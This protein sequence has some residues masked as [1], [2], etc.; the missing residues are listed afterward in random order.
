MKP[1]AILN[2]VAIL[3]ALG[4]TAFADVTIS[5]DTMLTGDADYSGQTVTVTANATLDLAGHKLTAASISGDGAI[6]SGSAYTP[7]DMVTT[8]ASNAGRI[9]TG[10]KPKSTDRIETKFELGDAAKIKWIFG[11]Y[12]SNKRMDCYTGSGNLTFQLGSITTN[13]A[14]SVG[15]TYEVVLDGKNSKA[16]VVTGNTTTELEIDETTY[17]PSSNIFLFGPSDSTDGRNVS[18]CTMYYFR[19]Y[20]EGGNLKL[21]LIPMKRIADDAVGFYDTE[22]GTFLTLSS[23]ELTGADELTSVTTASDNTGYI[24][25]G[26]VPSCTDRVETK[27]NFAEYPSSSDGYFWLFSART[28]STAADLFE[29]YLS[30]NKHLYI[31]RCA[32][33]GHVGVVP[34]GTDLEIV[35][36]AGA[37]SFSINGEA[38]TPS[39]GFNNSD[40]T[41]TKCFRLFA[42]HPSGG[43]PCK[44]VT[45]YYFRVFDS[46]GALKMN[47]VPVKRTSDNAV[48]FCDRVRGGFYK[49]NTGTLSG[50][51][52]A[53]Q[54]P[55]ALTASGGTCTYTASNGKT[56]TYGD[57][58]NLFNNNFTYSTSDNTK[59]VYFNT[60]NALPVAF[61]YDFTEGKIVNAYS[62]WCGDP[63]RGPASW[64][65]YGSNESAAYGA[66]SNDG[67]TKLD[68]QTLQSG[69][70]N[71]ECR[72]KVFANNTEYRY[73]RLEILEGGKS[74]YFDLTQ[75]EY[76]NI[77][78]SERSGEL[79]LA[80][81]SATANATVRLGGDLKLVKEGEGT[82]T[83]SKAGQGYSGGTEIVD[84]KLVADAE[85]SLGF[86][87]VRVADGAVLQIASPLTLSGE[88]SMAEGSKLDFM[89]PTKNSAPTLTLSGGATLPAT[90]NLGILRGGD[91]Q[92][93]GDG[94]ALTAGYDF[95]GTLIGF[96]KTAYARRVAPDASGNLWVYGPTGMVIVFR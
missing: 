40:F 32:N 50:S 74:Q 5:R 85:Q 59:R 80:S 3:S 71:G 43:R 35:F 70:A 82:F 18:S 25:T 94:L 44:N 22:S 11:T 28:I 91:F 33:A 8:P 60:T 96:E 83:A 53:V 36:D 24:D 79:H 93:P 89:F 42:N 54:T 17:T 68:S 81:D 92:L 87:G 10:Y 69:W 57:V 77:P 21:N 63:D 39:T 12:T 16:V 26:Y 29:C 72:T 58:G 90:L 66:V 27:V 61:D 6:S 7:V 55:E 67:W 31:D 88:L 4:G 51:A 15:G 95:R 46:T 65:F 52:A 86:G 75:L 84:G 14:S 41:P 56:I 49:L 78:S 30:A 64:A 19:V 20:D 2:G 9:D 47:L 34:T 73:Y 38:K 1:A 62:I 23:G 76:Y 13:I 37:R 48:G 45:M